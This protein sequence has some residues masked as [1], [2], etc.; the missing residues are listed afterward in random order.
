MQALPQAFPI[1]LSAES[2]PA[3]QSCFDELMLIGAGWDEVRCKP[4]FEGGRARGEASQ[5]FGGSHV[6]RSTYGGRANP[7]IYALALPAR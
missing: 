1:A 5:N 6:V 2:R 3:E 7:S 4:L